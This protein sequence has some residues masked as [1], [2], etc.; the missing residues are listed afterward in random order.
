ML[1]IG[2]PSPVTRNEKQLLILKTLHGPGELRDQAQ[3]EQKIVCESNSPRL[4][5]LV[6]TQ[7]WNRL[8]TDSLLVGFGLLRFL[9]GCNDESAVA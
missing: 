4:P 9:A 6:A 1:V 7:G 2:D 8:A 5:S 3:K